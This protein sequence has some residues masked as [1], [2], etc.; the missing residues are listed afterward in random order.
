MSKWKKK[1]YRGKRRPLET[2]GGRR[3]KK[4]PDKSRKRGLS[5]QLSVHQEVSPRES[6]LTGLITQAAQE[7]PP[8]EKEVS[9]S[10]RKC[11]F[12][13]SAPQSL[14][15]EGR[16]GGGGREAAQLNTRV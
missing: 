8:E 16:E 12:A 13:A 15:P 2:H 1:Q 14:D 4:S 11:V 9:T 6:A 3:T 5:P 7:V 10:Y